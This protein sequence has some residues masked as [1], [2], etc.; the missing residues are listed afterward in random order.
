M[1]TVS[2]IPFLYFLERITPVHDWFFPLGL[3]AAVVGI[4]YAWAIYLLFRYVKMN[5]L[6][7]LAITIVLSGVIDNLILNH[8]ISAYHSTETSQLEYIISVFCYVVVSGVLLILGYM[9]N[10]MKNAQT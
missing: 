1:L 7:K 3:P 10:K 2:V 6:Y 9:K 5:L 8:I 4:V